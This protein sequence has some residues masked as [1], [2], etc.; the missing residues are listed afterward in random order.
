M[1][2]GVHVDALPDDGIGKERADVLATRPV[3]E[4]PF[5]GCEIVLVARE[6]YVAEQLGPHPDKP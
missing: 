3:G 2:S 4:L 1:T 6:L 5:E